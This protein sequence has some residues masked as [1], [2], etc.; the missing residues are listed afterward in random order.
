MSG[1]FRGAAVRVEEC[2]TFKGRKDNCV[3]SFLYV[4]AMFSI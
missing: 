2:H 3:V 1:F 4:V